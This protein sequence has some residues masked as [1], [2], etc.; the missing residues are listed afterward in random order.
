MYL[1][2]SLMSVSISAIIDGRDSD[3]VATRRT[4]LG[5]SVLKK[6]SSKF[7]R[8]NVVMSGGTVFDDNHDQSVVQ[9]LNIA[10][11]VYGC[12]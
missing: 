4:L 5:L 10:Q 9:Y 11:L 8:S 3:S 1:S 7:G 2:M 6:L 12:F